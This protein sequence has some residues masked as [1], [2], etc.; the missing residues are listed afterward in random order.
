MSEIRDLEYGHPS[1][2][3]AR[4]FTASL[5]DTSPSSQAIG[6]GPERLTNDSPAYPFKVDATTFRLLWDFGTPTAVLYALLVHHNCVA[7]L[8]GVR[9]A[10]GSTTGTTDFARDFTIRAYHEDAFPMNEHLDLRDVAPTYQYA[11][12]EVT[13]PNSVNCALG[14]FPML[15]SVRALDGN[16][17]LDAEDDES[18]PLVEHKT[19]VGVSTI[20]QHGTRLRWLRGEKIQAATDAA[21]IRSWN[22]ATF[23]RGLPFV[24]IPHLLDDDA[25]VTS[26]AV[27]QEESWIVR[28]EDPNLPRT[29]MGPDLMSRYRLKFEE[30]SRGLKPTPSAV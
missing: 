22:R 21:A 23:G 28:W 14:A 17:L 18:H 10:M 11:S 19:D 15:T 12:L 25:P 9:F 1:D 7:G 24:L 30:V 13:S 29:Y 5:V 16:L 3:L 8:G 4:A 27:E 20:Y 2:D 26:P 6:Y